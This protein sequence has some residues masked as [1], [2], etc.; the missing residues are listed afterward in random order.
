M[1]LSSHECLSCLDDIGMCYSYL[2][3]LLSM[4]LI[5]FGV[6]YKVFLKNVVKEAEMLEKAA[7]YDYTKATRFL[8]PS[9]TI[10]N[11]AS[12]AV[13]SIALTVVLLSLGKFVLGEYPGTS[14]ICFHCIFSL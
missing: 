12:A 8:A 3:Q 2:I 7:E 10:T 14:G 11:E 9:P 13:F 1:S 6:M 4:A 5:V